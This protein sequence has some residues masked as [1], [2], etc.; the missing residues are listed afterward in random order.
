MRYL[1]F[2]AVSKQGDFYCEQHINLVD[3]I[4]AGAKALKKG[5]TLF[6]SREAALKLAHQYFP[7]TA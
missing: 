1:T 7:E 2:Y 5:H 4:T 6:E 3:Y